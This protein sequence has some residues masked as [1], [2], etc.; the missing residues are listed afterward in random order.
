MNKFN[1]I[2]FFSFFEYIISESIYYNFNSI[3]EE[4]NNKSNVTDIS[5]YLNI[6]TN[7]NIILTILNKTNTS[8]DNPCIQNIS[9]NYHNKPQEI[10]KIYE[11]SSKGFDD[12]NSFTTCINDENNTYFSFYPNW[13]KNARMDIA[14]LN[15]ENLTEHLWIFGICLKRDICES[16][17]I[18]KIFD[19]VN[20]IFNNTFKLYSSKNISIDDYRKVKDEILSPLNVFLNFIPSYFVPIQII[21]MIF[22]IIPIK[23]FSCCLRRKYIRDNQKNK[24]A[25]NLE[26]SFNIASLSRQIALKIRKCF[27]ISEIIEDF[28]TSKRNELFKDED[29]TYIKGIKTFGVAFF[30][31]GM[32]FTILYNYPL[33]SS[34]VKEREEYMKRGFT[35]ILIIAFRISP[36]LILSSS[37]YS[38]SYK[39]LNFLDKKLTSFIPEKRESL[40]EMHNESSNSEDNSESFQ[41]GQTAKKMEKGKSSSME[42]SSENTKSF[43]ENTIGIKF[44]S[45]DISK[46]TLNKI[47]KG[48]KI[49]ENL[50]LK[51]ISTDKIPYI[52]YFNFISRQIHRLFTMTIGMLSM[53]MSQP[54]LTLYF[55]GPLVLYIYQT[56]FR[57]MG[58]SG[59][60][61]L[62]IGNFLDLFS[63][64]VKNPLNPFNEN[65]RFSMMQLFCIPMSEFNYFMIGSV[66]IF[67]C[68]KKRIRLDIILIVLIF[69]DILFKIFF[70]IDDLDNRN[71]GMF[72]TDTD[73][74]RFFFNPIFNM[75]FYLIGMLFGIVNY[76]VQNGL[77]NK[78]S[79]IKK[80]PFVKIPLCISRLCLYNLKGCLSKNYG[81]FIFIVLLFIFSLIIVPILFSHNF[82]DIIEKNNPGFFFV[83]ISLIDIELF[84]YCFHFV[85]MACYISGQN[86]FFKLLNTN[87]ASYGMKLGFWVVLIVPTLTY[88]LIYNNE[89]NINLN[90]FMVLIYGSI[91][92]VNSIALALIFFL[93]LEMP[94]KKLI[95][96]Y[97][98][99]SD[100]LNKLYLENEKDEINEINKSGDIG[101]NDELNEKDL[102]LENQGENINNEGV[103]E[104]NENDIDNEEEFK[105]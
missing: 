7:L 102:L 11:G 77:A 16:D 74:Q 48:Q 92:F 5:K 87:V 14:R 53:R 86:A 97:F 95:K 4:A 63:K 39:F 85:A 60:N 8:Q 34:E 105:D 42:S 41:L 37:G 62:Y 23:L 103:K 90:F 46:S 45:K 50:L 9:K 61:Y 27:S 30:V 15:G 69:V 13:D 25:T 1:F 101:L 64:D 28:I 82:E 32:S 94:Y 83:A 24:E 31:F 91:T 3:N 81:H 104:I 17:D 72:Y 59:L 66:L 10:I 80:R 98:N 47:F 93:V 79:L 6:S 36:A 38:L 33:C 100:E 19:A 29:M 73:Y 55:G 65:K 12:M 35:Y 44:Y 51:D 96:L 2:F 67:I 68:Y 57:N 26:S 58:T 22:K 84:T 89:A 40:T 20:I 88:L 43:Y 99:I 56:F 18:K 49:N 78:E 54:I 70:I 71:P 21:F 76:V 52:M 75:D